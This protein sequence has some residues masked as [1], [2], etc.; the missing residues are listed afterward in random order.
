MKS[1]ELRS[2]INGNMKEVV[3]NPDFIKIYEIWKE[4]FIARCGR[5]PKDIDV[6]Y[7]GYVLSNP[8]VRGKY[9]KLIYKEHESKIN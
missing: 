7:A 9:K 3:M 5:E 4:K 2:L 6:F 1:I 8:S